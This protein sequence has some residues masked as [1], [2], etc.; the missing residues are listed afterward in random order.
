MGPFENTEIR[1]GVLWLEWFK[2]PVFRYVKSSTHRRSARVHQAKPSWR[3]T[4]RLT[5]ETCTEWS[6]AISCIEWQPLAYARAMEALRVA[7][8]GGSPALGLTSPLAG[9]LCS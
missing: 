9:R 5:V 6:S 2:T 1:P 7:E 8:S 3:A 4:A